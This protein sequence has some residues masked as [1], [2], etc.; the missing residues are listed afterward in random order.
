MVVKSSGEKGYRSFTVINA[1]K[2]GGC[3]TKSKGGRYISTNAFGAA[4][5][6]FN[7]LCRV[8]K[9]RG[10]CTLTI[11]VRETTS[12]SKGKVFT[13]KMHRRKL[14]EPLI[15]L[16][17]TPNEFVV[18][19]QVDGHSVKSHKSC[20]KKQNGQSVGKMSQKTKKKRR[21]SAN[22]VRKLFQL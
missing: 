21:L 15:R 18:E 4:K 16:E 2:H 3:K 20:K 10:V 11:S 5:K 19:Y 14:K 1:S 17:G 22:N 6:A 13:Y 7:E 8:K 12:G 9:I